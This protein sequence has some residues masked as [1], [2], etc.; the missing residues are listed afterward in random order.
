M[1]R[2]GSVS[3]RAFI[4][5]LMRDCGLTYEEARQGFNCLVSI[6][7][8]AVINK[9]AVRFG[10]FGVLMPVRKPPREVKM[11]FRRLPGN[12]MVKV[13]RVYHLDERFEWRLRVY[14][15]FKRRNQLSN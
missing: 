7:E 8:N 1:M 15:E 2:S 4:Q 14:A 5:K 11:G 12:K 3:R 13:K 6:L 9:E 10:R